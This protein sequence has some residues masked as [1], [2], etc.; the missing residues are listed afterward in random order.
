M[1]KDS[2]ANV[3]Y[4]I[5]FDQN[6]V[7]PWD[8]Y[9]GGF[10]DWWSD[11][12]DYASNGFRHPLADEYVPIA[13]CYVGSH[14]TDEPR[15]LAL[16]ESIQSCCSEEP[17]ILKTPLIEVDPLFLINFCKKYGIELQEHQ[18]PQWYLVAQTD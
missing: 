15:I 14:S 18:T 6:F 12:S 9:P 3:C 2:H 16:S 7:F 4:G 10:E 13:L 17:E 5:L 8:D 1:S 11:E